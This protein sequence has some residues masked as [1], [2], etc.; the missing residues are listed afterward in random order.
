M[1]RWMDGLEY[2]A[3]LELSCLLFWVSRGFIVWIFVE[4]I[5][6]IWREVAG[7]FSSVIPMLS[8]L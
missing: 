3:Y 1:D 5:I 8:I 2:F 7:S 4:R 6:D